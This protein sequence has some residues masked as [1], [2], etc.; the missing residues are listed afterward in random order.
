M[1]KP[2]VLYTPS[3]C[4]VW[5]WDD[6]QNQFA[7]IHQALPCQLKQVRIVIPGQGSQL[8]YFAPRFIYL[9]K[10]T[11]IRGAILGQTGDRFLLLPA[12]PMAYQ[13]WDVQPMNL[14]SPR[15]YLRAV[16]YP[17]TFIPPPP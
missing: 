11:D 3:T 9:Q 5:R 13:T 2:F 1:A 10:R 6:V 14:D 17:V 12:H 4:D 7:R 8:G 15:E 16:V